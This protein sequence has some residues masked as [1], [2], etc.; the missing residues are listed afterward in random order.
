MFRILQPRRRMLPMSRGYFLPIHSRHPT[1]WCIRLLGSSHT[2]LPVSNW[3]VRELRAWLGSG[4]PSPTRQGWACE[5]FLSPSGSGRPHGPA[6]PQTSLLAPPP[7]PRG[8]AAPVLAPSGLRAF[9]HAVPHT[10]THTSSGKPSLTWFPPASL[11][12]MVMIQG[13]H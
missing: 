7:P 12:L 4:H 1:N 13:C 8:L 2:T 9:A 6:Q 3:E 11:F 5:M 10:R